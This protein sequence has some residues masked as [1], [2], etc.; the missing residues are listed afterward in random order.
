MKKLEQLRELFIKAKMLVKEGNIENKSEVKKCLKEIADDCRELYVSNSSYMERAKCRNLYENLENVIS[1]LEQNGFVDEGVR[2]FFGLIAESESVPTFKAVSCEQET[3]QNPELPTLPWGLEE[4]EVVSETPKEEKVEKALPPPPRPTVYREKPTKDIAQGY[5][6]EPALIKTLVEEDSE[7]VKN[8]PSVTD[9]PPP[10]SLD[11]FI[12]Q[13]HIVERLK[14]EIEVARILGKKHLD[15]ILLQGNRGLGK[16]TL[17]KLLAKELGVRFEFIDCTS[18]MNDTRSQRMFHEFFQ[19]IASSDEPVLIACD[20]IHA[21]PVRLQSNLLTLLN[22]RIYSYLTESG[23]KI[24]T[25]PEFTFVAATTDYDAVLS[26]VKDRCSNLSFIMKDYTRDELY[27]I[28]SDKFIGMG[29]TASANVIGLCINRCRSSIRDVT[30]IVKGL[31]SK[32]VLA[33]TTAVIED[34]V[35]E[36]FSRMGVDAIG[37]K[38][39]ERR[40]LQ[41]IAD[42]PNGYISEETLAA[43]VYLNTKVLTKEYEPYLMKIGFL[44]VGL[45]GRTLTPKAEEYLRYGYFEFADGTKVGEKP[46]MEGADL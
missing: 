3:I 27:R 7:T 32:A 4:G 43:R 34:M 22:D 42:E 39:I 26:T 13:A 31:Y 19:R 14:E 6:E 44:S 21:M 36:Y 23:T 17:M 15:N 1:L 18:L 46:V 30:A 20:E 41:A 10:Q 11:E 25:M 8:R 16:S 2:T 29:I 33:K 38:E 9:V 45:R 40:I 28:F 37:L 35:E 12:G 5:E 24:L